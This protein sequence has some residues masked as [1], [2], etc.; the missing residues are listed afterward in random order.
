MMF[1]EVQSLIQADLCRKTVLKTVHIPVRDIILMHELYRLVT[2]VTRSI[3][4]RG[5]KDPL[6]YLHEKRDIFSECLKRRILVWALKGMNHDGW[7]IWKLNNVKQSHTM[8]SGAREKGLRGE[9]LVD[10]KLIWTLFVEPFQHHGSSVR[11]PGCVHAQ[12]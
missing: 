9:K 1:P 2:R 6:K 3:K 4:L 12:T 5:I 7:L 8:I 10:L 11:D